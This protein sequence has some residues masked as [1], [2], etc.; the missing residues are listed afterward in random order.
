M[1]TVLS[2]TGSPGYAQ[3]SDAGKTW[4]VYTFLSSGSITFDTGGVAEYLVIGGG[5]G[6]GRRNFN[7]GGAGGAGGVLQSSWTP[8]SGETFDI[9]VGA[10]G[11]GVAVDSQG[12]QGADSVLALSGGAEVA[13]A[14]GGGYGDGNATGG[15]TGGVGGSGGGGRSDTNGGAGT[16]GQGSAGGNGTNGSTS[17]HRS[18]GGGGGQSGAGGNAT[19]GV[20][21]A[22]GAGLT[23][24]FRTGA[25]ENFAGGGGGGSR[26]T[27]GTATH[28][29]GAGGSNGNGVDATA[30]TGGG[31]GGA[32]NAGSSGA[33]GS[34]IIVVRVEV[35]A[36][37]P[38]ID[39]GGE[40]IT[41]AVGGLDLQAAGTIDIGDAT[42]GIAMGGLDLV[43]PLANDLQIG[44]MT[45]AAVMGGLDLIVAGSID[46]GGASASITMGGLNL[47]LSGVTQPLAITPMPFDGYVFDSA[48]G[49]V[50]AVTIA[51]QGT[52]G[53][54]VQVR[55]AS[56]GGN[57]SW[58]ATTV[59][60]LGDWSITFDVPL[61]EW[62]NWYQPEARIGTDDLT[63]ITDAAVFGCGDVLG[64]FGQSE[65]EHIL[66]TAIAYNGL[67]YP[68]LD[69]ENITMITQAGSVGSIVP[70]RI[71]TT[72]I[73]I[74]NVAMVAIANALNH[75]RPNRKL[76]IVDFSVSG[77]SRIALANNANTGRNWAAEFKAKVDL[78]RSGGSDLGALI[79]CYYNA[80]AATIDSFLTEWAPFYFGQRAGG[81]A[82]TLGTPNPDSVRNP[83]ANIDNCLWDVE[84]PSDQRGRGIFARDRTKLHIMTPMP[85][86][87]TLTTEQRNFNYDGSGTLIAS[88]IQQL[89]RPA[90]DQ[91]MAFAA[92]SRV[93]TFLG[94]VGPSA[95]IVDFNGGIHPLT[96]SEW[97]TPQFA[98]NF[99][100]SMLRATGYAVGEPTFIGY[101]VAID[102]SYVDRI[103]D[104][105][106]GGTL[107][108]LRILDGLADPA[109]EPPHYQA[110][111]GYEIRRAGDSDAARRPVM[112]LTETGYPA[113]Y[114]GTVTIFDTGTGIAPARTGRVRITP[115]VPFTTGDRIEYLRGEA[116]GH[117]LEPRDVNAKLFLDQ[118]I[119][120]VPAFYDAST[121]YPMRGVPVQPQPAMMTI[122]LTPSIAIDGATVP[123][124]MGGVDLPAAGTVDIG[125]TTISIAMGGVDLVDPA[126]ADIP[127][128]GMSIGVVV[129]GIDLV[130][131]A[132]IDFGSAALGITMGG[133]DL[134]SAGQ[135]DIGGITISV[136]MGDL[137]LV[138]AN[139]APRRVALAVG[140]RTGVI[141]KR[142]ANG[143]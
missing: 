52:T 75:I 10:G 56:V 137:L 62:A 66:A 67:P 65:P 26:T 44:A 120:H 128:A 19:P 132:T 135:I 16:S 7:A 41:I 100:P 107:T 61:A 93:L 40:S 45:A 105:P 111:N 140:S 98:M 109:T 22:G 139:A 13:R 86:H 141:L 70:R 28:G 30:N 55:G 50:A 91:V 43:D 103:Y 127:I 11:A 102:G 116:N 47:V 94:S 31:G 23:T 2:T 3:I 92:D 124:T 106:N 25:S 37:T 60:I 46:I 68:A 97:G 123:V 4:D 24:T 49:I 59:D 121:L 112:K 113:N 84:A 118:L 51:G 130:A 39:I 81:G 73:N 38:T 6:G 115:E 99:L 129:G 15:T 78:I 14:K 108:T 122:S 58:H 131:A 48:D 133:V 88:R 8:G 95:H 90:R 83:S 142:T 117:I 21:G 17:L 63:K 76:M 96:D 5:A 85:F 71:D 138:G 89:D 134:A 9:T 77:E 57:T 20:G 119:E 143:A 42:I 54:D 104:L 1:T 74:V 136:A 72:G 33:G 18:G 79:E 53:D 101:E 82:F 29:G 27:G 80:D 12:N 87:D 114:R 125:A 36:S 35:I 34:G 64:I 32:G 69:A 110:V 126:A